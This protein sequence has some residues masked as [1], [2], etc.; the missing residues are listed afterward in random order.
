MNYDEWFEDLRDWFQP[1][2]ELSD[3]SWTVSFV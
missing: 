2:E 1:R 3:Q